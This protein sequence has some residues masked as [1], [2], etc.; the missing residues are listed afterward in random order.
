MD[1]QIWGQNKNYAVENIEKIQNKAMRILNF[2][3]P[4]AEASNLSKESTIYTLK[5]I[6][7]I[8]NCRFV[9]E[10][11]K[12]NLPKNFNNYFTVKKNQ[13]LYNTRRKKLDVPIVNTNYYVSNSRTLKAI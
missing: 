1:C 12:K 13:H 8:E 4:R 2:K 10:Q 6:T 11:I 9:Y 7:T 5:E 3:G